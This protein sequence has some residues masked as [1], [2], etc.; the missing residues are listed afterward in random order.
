M[1]NNMFLVFTKLNIEKT[2]HRLFKTFCLSHRRNQFTKEFSIKLN[3]NKKD[4]EET[5][6]IKVDV[7]D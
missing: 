2:K 1:K 3:S 6:F 4:D 5:F 7:S